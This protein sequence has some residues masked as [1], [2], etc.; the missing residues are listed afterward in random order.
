MTYAYTYVYVYIYIYACTHAYTHTYM[1]GCGVTHRPHIT[2]EY[3]ALL[4]E[5]IGLF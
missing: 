3:R 2:R 1:S 4:R 5:N